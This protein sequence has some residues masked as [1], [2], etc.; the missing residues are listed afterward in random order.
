MAKKLIPAV[1]LIM[2]FCFWSVSSAFADA[3]VVEG[4]KIFIADDDVTVLTLDG[5]FLDPLDPDS[6]CLG[7]LVDLAA[8]AGAT[9]VVI[10]DGMAIVTFGAPGS[11]DVEIVDV[12]CL[13]DYVDVEECFATVDFDTGKMEI[14]CIEVD[15][16][17]YT[18]RMDQRGNS[19]NWEVTFVDKND[20]LLNYRRKGGDDDDEDGDDDD[21]D[22]S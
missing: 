3:V 18:V 9:D 8:L 19:M 1:L 6:D 7:A 20:N 4:G 12:S 17:V 14:P 15:G 22:G 5:T 21:E 13:L 11:V 16:V 10:D 2:T